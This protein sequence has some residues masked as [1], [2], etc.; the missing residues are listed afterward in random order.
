MVQKTS[1]EQLGRHSIEF[2]KQADKTPLIVVLDNVR[3]MLNVGSI[4]RTCDA[5]AVQH[6]Y[7]CGITPTPPHREIHKTAL[8][9]E[10]AVS[11]SYSQDI[12]SVLHQLQEER[13]IIWAVEQTNASVPL[14]QINVNT[15][16]INVLVFGNEVEG[17]CDV[18]LALCHNY[19]EI[20]QWGTKHSLNVAVA[21]GV[22][23]WHFV[24]CLR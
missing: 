3:S 15:D 16:Q 1:M 24:A 12:S 10:D 7:L 23:M 20:P 21:A 4:F 5:F 6:L 8:G 13:K 2:F 11:W 22:A 9:S 19:I 18:A 17:I 14:H